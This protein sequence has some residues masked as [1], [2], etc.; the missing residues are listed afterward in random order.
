[1]WGEGRG[2]G[3]KTKEEEGGKGERKKRENIQIFVTC[4]Q[5]TLL[6]TNANVHN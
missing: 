4:E 1:V 5:A 3:R 6:K 2:K